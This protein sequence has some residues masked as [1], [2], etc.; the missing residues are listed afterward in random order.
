MLKTY[1]GLVALRHGQSVPAVI[2]PAL[3]CG[4]I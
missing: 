4:L 3:S 1:P 2:Q